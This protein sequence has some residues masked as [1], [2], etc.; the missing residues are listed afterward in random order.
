MEYQI[1]VEVLAAVFGLLL[2][3]FANVC[4][5][6]MAADESVV[7]PRSHCRECGHMI[8]WYDNVPVLSFVLLRAR[9]RYC[10]APIGW[11][12]PI[13][14]VLTGV[15]FW[16]AVHWNG[17]GWAG[18]K[19]CVFGFILVALSTMDLETRI[20]PDEF[21]LGG[22][23]AG[24][25]FAAVA[26]PRAGIVSLLLDLHSPIMAG[27]AEAGI[28]SVSAALLLWFIGWFYKRLNRL[29]KREIDPLGDGDPRMLGM[30]AAFLGLEGTILTLIVAGVAG[31]VLGVV[32]TVWNRKKVLSYELPFGTFLGA[33]GLLVAV[34]DWLGWLRPA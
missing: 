28:A 20:L 14:E 1:L 34:I 3:S 4:I 18:A 11:R 5:T 16:A 25:A 27:L 30:M 21:T 26:P 23:L 8:A 12:Y 2:G 22:W 24:L 31:S 19:W 9:C 15:W 13:V 10:H 29:W 6:R 17:A 7:S 33:A 32:W